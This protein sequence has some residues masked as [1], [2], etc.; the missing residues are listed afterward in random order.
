MH[1][2]MARPFQLVL[3]AL[4]V[5]ACESGPRVRTDYD[6][7][8]DFSRYR[9]YRVMGPQART[10]DENY[11]SLI[12]R[13]I[14]AAIDR[15]MQSRGYRPAPDADLLVNFTVT[16]QEKVSVTSTPTAAPAGYYGYRR[17]HYRAWGGY[18][19]ETRVRQYNEGTL[20]IDLVDASRQIMIW[21]GVAQGTITQRVRDNPRE[22]IDTAVSAVF[23]EYAYTAS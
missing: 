13:R 11:S 22:A 14:I 16:V 6:P 20:I 17:G 7:S 18:A 3:L 5:A 1:V 19:Y 12:E 15:E 9:T 23:A 8:V 21:E 10:S 4:L 2:R